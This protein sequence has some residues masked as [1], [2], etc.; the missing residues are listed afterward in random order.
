MKKSLEE[1]YF[2]NPVSNSLRYLYANKAITLISSSLLGVFLPIFLFDLFDGDFRLVALFFGVSSLAYALVVALSA[3]FLNK[4]GFRKSLRISLFFGALF[5]VIFYFLDKS[6]FVYLIPLSMVV[7][8][9]FRVLY[10]LPY[11]VDMAKFT[12]KKNRGR[13]MSVLYAFKMLVGVFSPFIAGFVI[14]KFGFDLLF[15]A[16]IVLYCLSYFPLLRIPRTEEKFSWGYRE[17]WRNTFSKGNRKVAF[18]F[19]A[20]GAESIVGV[21]VWP[22]FMY[23]LLNGDYLQV[24]MITTLLTGVTVVLQLLVGKTIDKK[25]KK[26]KVLGLGSMLYAF[27]WVIKI[28]IVTAFQ[29]FITGA[30]HSIVK[31]FMRTPFDALTYDLAADNGHYV[32]EFTVIHEIMFHLGKA[33]MAVMVIFIYATMAIQWAFLLA[34]G[35]ALMLNFLRSGNEH[36]WIRTHL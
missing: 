34:A 2:D 25:M 35:A 7:L 27:G 6:N 24:G 36:F 1:K 15:V 28:F 17:A 20:D 29:I 23:Q 21:V 10:W 9:V 11:H 19:W 14:V 33:S 30:Y 31:I 18:A 3:Q 26:E 4:F 32:D 12:D 13:E 8:V 22:I 16:A 5:Y